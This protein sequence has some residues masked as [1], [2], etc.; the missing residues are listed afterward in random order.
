MMRLDR[1]PL[2]GR[3][4]KHRTQAQDANSAA[5]NEILE[6]LRPAFQADGGDLTLTRITPDGRVL[7]RAHGA[8]H[9]CG[10]SILTL[11]GAVAPKLK[12]RLPWVTGVELE[13]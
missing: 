1:V 7:L 4:F 13:E 5:V 3:F 8:C 12:E 6:E 11:Q 2:F 9:G 10:A